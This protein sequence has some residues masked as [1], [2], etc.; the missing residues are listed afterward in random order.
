MIRQDIKVLQADAQKQR[1]VI[2]EQI[3]SYYLNSYNMIATQA[4]LMGGF[5]FGG[6]SFHDNT[7]LEHDDDACGREQDCSGWESRYYGIPMFI[8][9]QTCCASTLLNLAAVVL[10]THCTIQAPGLQLLGP[11]GST[12]RACKLLVNWHKPTLL[13]F[14][15]GI[16]LFLVMMLDIGWMQFSFWDTMTM[17]IQLVLVTVITVYAIYK[18]K[19]EFYFPPSVILRDDADIEGN[20][21]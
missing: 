3:V 15:V 2:Q 8:Y 6:Y 12:A 20:H 4:A 1:I 11:E 19:S 7:W 18:M 16:F 10:A 9:I 13:C 5:A 21:E 14:N 17:T